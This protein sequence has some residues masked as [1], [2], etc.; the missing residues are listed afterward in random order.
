MVLVRLLLHKILNEERSPASTI[1]SALYLL[2]LRLAD[3]QTSSGILK[4]RRGSV[5]KPDDEFENPPIT[6]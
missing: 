1:T 2:S 5:I 4:G 3:C 6:G